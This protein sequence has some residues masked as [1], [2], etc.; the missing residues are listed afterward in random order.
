MLQTLSIST[1]LAIAFALMAAFFWGS[2]AIVLKHTRQVPMEAFYLIM[3]TSSMI[4]IWVAGFSLEGASLLPGIT[5]VW[6]KE[7]LRIVMSFVS[8]FVYIWTNLM[9]LKVMQRVGLSLSQPVN[10][11]ISLIVGTGVSY[12]IGGIP[13]G[14]KVWRLILSA[15]FLVTAIF[16]TSFAGEARSKKQKLK[17]GQEKMSL[18]LFAMA[19]I[20][21]LTGVIYSTAISFGLKSI[22]QPHG[23]S[24]MGFLVVLLSGAWVG[25]MFLCVI[26]LTRK[27]EWGLFRA[28]KPSFYLMIAAASSLHYL[29][30]ILNG[31]AT[32][33]LSS[34]ISW[35]L[36]M[37]A[38]LWTQ[39][40]GMVYGEFNDAPKKAYWLLGSGVACYLIGAFVLSNL[41]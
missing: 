37:T 5:E 8:G 23:L 38:G 16:L 30:N 21:A 2:W 26:P 18:R 15:V 12:L 39:F 1:P 9:S 7:P 11:S 25:A 19:L 36:S 41:F 33:A 4:F 27:K 14:T 13:S 20:G 28:L 6:R 3:F 40:W 24:V 35:P 22:S 32:K 31:M 34:A 10:S 17:P 29:G